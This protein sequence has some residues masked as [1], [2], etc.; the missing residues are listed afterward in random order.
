MELLE[1]IKR[2]NYKFTP[3][4]VKQLEGL[5]GT[6]PS[7]TLM[8]TVDKSAF[9]QVVS[10]LQRITGVEFT[11]ETINILRESYPD[12]RIKA[13]K[14]VRKATG[15]GLKEAKHVVD[16]AWPYHIVNQRKQRWTKK[17]QTFS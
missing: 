10:D 8:E 16:D 11:A 6:T 13:I 12:M 4:M 17:K 5:I 3:T 2:N 15:S 7:V 1:K 14:E 9:P